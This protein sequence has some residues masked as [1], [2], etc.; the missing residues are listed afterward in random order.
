MSQVHVT[1]TYEEEC[2]RTIEMVFSTMLN[3]EITP[4]PPETPAPSSILTAAIYFAG[5]WRG[6]VLLESSE[7]DACLLAGRLMS[8]PRPPALNEDVRDSL[9]ELVNMIGGNLKP[10]LPHGVVLSMPSVIEGRQYA[11][12]LN[13]T[14]VS[15][16]AFY[17]GDDPMWVTLLE[18]P[19]NK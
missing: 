8:I 11:L 1:R 9:S 19:E 18:M 7:P 5:A 14:V 16:Q 2:S 3:L 15:R 13:A 4:V 6:A 12:R 10:V 17:F